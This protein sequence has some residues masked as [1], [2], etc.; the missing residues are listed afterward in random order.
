[1][2]SNVLIDKDER[3]MN[4][5]ITRYRGIIESLLNLTTSRS[6]NMFSVSICVRDQSSPN[7]S[8]FNIVKHIFTYLNG[9]SQHSLWYPKGSSCSLVGYFDSNFVGCKSDRIITS[10]TCHLF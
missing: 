4:F 10:C 7:E 1:M 9:T 6:N 3:G 5:N 2:E 8:H